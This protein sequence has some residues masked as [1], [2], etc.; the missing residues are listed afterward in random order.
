MNDSD[1]GH[2]LRIGWIH[3]RVRKRGCRGAQFHPLR[4]R[5]GEA[6]E[7]IVVAAITGDDGV[8]PGCQRRNGQRGI[9]RCIHRG[10]AE[11]RCAVGEGH[12]ARH[13]RDSAIGHGGGQ[14]DRAEGLRRTGAGGQRDR[15]RLTHIERKRS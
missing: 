6:G 14:Q 11:K 8:V 7:V 15:G 3:L 9:A 13:R 4:Q 12:S 1:Q 10:R 2:L 5:W